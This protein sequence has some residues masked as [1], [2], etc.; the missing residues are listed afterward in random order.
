MWVPLVKPVESWQKLAVPE[1]A[2]PCLKGHATSTPPQPLPKGSLP[3]S[4]SSS[5]AAVPWAHM[6]A[7]LVYGGQNCEIKQYNA[8]EAAFV[9]LVSLLHHRYVSIQAN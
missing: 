1:L 3:P 7:A 5:L 2:S 4:K 9:T 8:W 6:H